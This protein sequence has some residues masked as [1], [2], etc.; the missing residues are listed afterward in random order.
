MM[1]SN[2]FNNIKISSMILITGVLGDEITTFSGISTGRI[3]EVNPFTRNLIANG[4]WPLFDVLL[5]SVCLFLSYIIAKNN[6]NELSR[7]M[8]L[9]PIIPG[10]VRLITFTSNL[11]LLLSL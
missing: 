4:I 2:Y 7:I 10:I 9:A 3:V 6:K 8:S 1:E 11:I 5:I